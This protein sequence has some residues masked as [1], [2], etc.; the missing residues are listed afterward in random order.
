M[1]FQIFTAMLLEWDAS[2][3]LCSIK[4]WKTMNFN[5]FIPQ[6]NP[7]APDFKEVDVNIKLHKLVCVCGTRRKHCF[8]S[9]DTVESSSFSPSS[10]ASSSTSFSSSMALQS[11][12]DWQCSGD[13]NCYQILDTYRQ[14]QR[15]LFWKR[16][17]EPPTADICKAFIL[18]QKNII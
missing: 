13:S 16:W 1:K 17:V 14:W 9:Y 12:V 2:G 11:N 6:N 3:L 10:S 5:Q 7:K 8:G 4:R 15:F 18:T